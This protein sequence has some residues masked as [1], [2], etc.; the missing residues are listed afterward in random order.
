VTWATVPL[1]IVGV[2]VVLLDQINTD[3]RARLVCG[4]S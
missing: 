3:P 4:V 2:T 1:A